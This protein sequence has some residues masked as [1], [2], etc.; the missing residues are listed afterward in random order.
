MK[1]VKCLS[2]RDIHGC[3]LDGGWTSPVIH[4]STTTGEKD[5]D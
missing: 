4:P 2:G 5:P 1:R 3:V